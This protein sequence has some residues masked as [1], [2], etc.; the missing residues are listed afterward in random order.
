MLTREVEN[1]PGFP[2]AI[3]GP[4]LMDKMRKQAERFGAKFVFQNATAVDF[5]S[6][7]FKISVNAQVFEGKSIIIATGASRK[8]LGIESEAKLRGRGVSYCATCDGP[9]FKE[10]TVVVVG[11]G[12]TAIDEALTLTKFAKEVIIVHRRDQLRATKILQ[13]RA[14]NNS[15]VRFVW[16]SI[17]EEI[18]GEKRVEGIRVKNVKTGE[19]S[20]VTANGVFIAIGNKPNTEIFVGQIEL[21]SDGYIVAEE[22]TKTNIDGVFVAGDVQDPRYRQAITAAGSGCKAALDVEKYL[23]EQLP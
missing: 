15:R 13:D 16:D 21:D 3:L 10:K 11:G 1:F 6:K 12:D 19:T 23:A 8:W 4:E 17:V 14:L 7:P 9:F 20:V 5:S 18:L 2:E 22:E